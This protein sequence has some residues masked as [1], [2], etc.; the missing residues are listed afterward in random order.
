[1]SGT[2]ITP[3]ELVVLYEDNH[4]LAV[5]KPAGVLVQADRTGDP[6]LQE[7]AR[8]WLK[9]RHGKPGNVFLGIVQRLDRPV[10]GVVLFAKTSKAAARL[11]E[12]FRRRTVEKEYR[13]VVFGTPSPARGTLVHHLRRDDATR[14]TQVVDADED[15]AQAA[16]LD[17][18]VLAAEGGRSLLAVRPHT[19]RAHQIRRQLAQAGH[20][21]LGDTKYGAPAPLPDRRI[22]LYAAHVAVQHP[23]RDERVRV[24][25]PEPPGWPWPPPGRPAPSAPTRPPGAAARCAAPKGA[26]RPRSDGPPGPPRGGRGGSSGRA[27]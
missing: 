8:A 2:A 12:Q 21:L 4:V 20:P 11:S 3:A 19:G 24:V 14:R 17:Y 15:G 26:P 27:R 23:T 6:S 7:T 10:A 5:F 13:A 25:S 16:S 18:E 22:A 9:E 1:M